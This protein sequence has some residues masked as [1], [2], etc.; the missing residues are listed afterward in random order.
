MKFITTESIVHWNENIIH[1]ADSYLMIISPFIQINDKMYELLCAAKIRGVKIILICGKTVLNET[2]KRKI[3]ELNAIMPDRTHVVNV[4]F[5]LK[6]HAKIFINEKYATVSSLNFYE[7]SE[8][9]EE[10]GFLVSKKY[11][12]GQFADVESFCAK[13]ITDPK[14]TQYYNHEFYKKE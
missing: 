1:Y 9:N 10:A 6:L 3:K 5:I 8:Q 11:D 2:D 4:F 12:V 13:L 14:H 7:A